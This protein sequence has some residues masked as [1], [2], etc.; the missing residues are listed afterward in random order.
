MPA[1]VLDRLPTA[2]RSVE[3]RCNRFA[4][5]LLLPPAELDRLM[6]DKQPSESAAVRIAVAEDL[7]LSREMVY[8]HFLDRGWISVEAY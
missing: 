3:I 6:A 7:N 8:R 4:A 5:D 1:D 2:S